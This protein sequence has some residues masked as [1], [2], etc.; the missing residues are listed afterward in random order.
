VNKVDTP[1]VNLASNITTIVN[2]AIQ[3]ELTASNAAGG[4][5]SPL[6]TFAKNRAFS[7][8]LQAESINNKV[9]INPSTLAV[10]TNW[11]YVRMK[12]SSNCFNTQFNIDSIMLERSTV[13]GIT[14]PDNPNQLITAFPNP[15]RDHVLIRGLKPLKIYVV[16]L[17]T[18]DGRKISS[19]QVTGEANTRVSLPAAPKGKYLLQI[20]DKRKGRFIGTIGLMKE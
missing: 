11:L 16:S 8:I 19:Q 15:Y 13:T 20:I 4:G 10:G 12:T 18:M 2:L 7:D 6:Y 9:S 14:D 17:S 3:V 1:D 5:S